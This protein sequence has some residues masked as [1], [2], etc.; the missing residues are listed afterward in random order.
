VTANP[1][2]HVEIERRPGWK[3][4][5]AAL[6]AALALGAVALASWP[7]G[8]TEASGPRVAPPDSLGQAPLPLVLPTEGVTP[9]SMRAGAE[10]DP[11]WLVWTDEEAAFSVHYPEN[12]RVIQ[13]Y[14]TDSGPSGAVPLTVLATRDVAVHNGR[15]GDAEGADG[16]GPADA[17]VAIYEV[18]AA[19]FTAYSGV[20]SFRPQV[21]DPCPQ[22]APLWDFA[23]F[24]LDGRDFVAF[25]PLGRYVS[26]SVRTEARRI[27]ES[28]TVDGRA[29][30]ARA[31]VTSDAPAAAD[32]CAHRVDGGHLS[33]R[34][35]GLRGPRLAL[36]VGGNLLTWRPESCSVTVVGVPTPARPLTSHVAAVDGELIVSSGPDQP[37]VVLPADGSG[38]PRPVGPAET[39]VTDTDRVWLVSGG[40]AV[41]YPGGEEQSAD[42][43]PLDAE[44]AP[45]LVFD[46]DD[47]TAIRWAGLTIPVG[48]GRG[49]RFPPDLWSTLVVDPTG[50]DLYLAI[51]VSRAERRILRV[52]IDGSNAS[53]VA[54]MSQTLGDRPGML[55]VPD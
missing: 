54:S 24:G 29:S 42:V 40:V 37:A 25:V 14:S 6:L 26:E 39:L 52:P 46:G 8:G 34:R 5:G 38:E 36:V 7:E 41:A 16:L 13:P 27:I 44:P 35:G 30:E 33:I 23:R 31:S 4:R 50:R 28:L 51:E 47:I 1:A 53:V 21:I 11:D 43:V 2:S 12:W 17:L 48:L 15:C 22:L 3:A 10:P 32:P 19:R 18:P 9:P 20:S 55:I 49:L 45:D